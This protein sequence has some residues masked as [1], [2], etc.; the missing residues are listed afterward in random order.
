M[1]TNWAL[2]LNVFMQIYFKL[3]EEESFIILILFFKLLIFFYFDEEIF[4]PVDKFQR[5]QL[6]SPFIIFR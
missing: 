2:K 6:I 3:K 5:I 1:D 4:R